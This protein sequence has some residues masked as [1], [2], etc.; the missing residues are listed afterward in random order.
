MSD[1]LIGNTGFIGS[2]LAEQMHFDYL[3]NSSNIED[4][5]GKRYKT[6]VSAANSGARWRSNQK[7]E[8]DLANIE[9]FI[10]HVNTVEADTFIL[11]ST[12]DVYKDPNGVDEGSATG[13]DDAN[14]YGK[15]RA[16]LE[17][18]I[19]ERFKR[20]LIIRL[21]ITYGMHFKKNLIYDVLNNHEVEKIDPA[22]KL[23]FYHV[24]RLS[25]DIQKALRAGIALLNM[26]TTPI[27]VKDLLK[28][29]LGVELANAPGRG[30]TYDMRTKYAKLFGKSGDYAY[31]REQ[32][33][34]DLHAFG[35]QY[36]KKA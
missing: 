4:I 29:A 35:T 20:H 5:R 24:A 25:T 16:Y 27:L 13:A 33:V 31:E 14:P 7:P 10:Q 8:E 30:M 34:E 19:K 11:V 15:H 18:F 26:A 3:Y 2:S 9:K 17:D 23:Q 21:P 1:A 22:A 28:E 6:I 12:I 36:G 32:V